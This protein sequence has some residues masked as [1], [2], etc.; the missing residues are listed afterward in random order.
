MVL[1][2]YFFILLLV[3]AFFPDFWGAYGGHIIITL[4]VLFALWLLY[5]LQVSAERRRIRA[6]IEEHAEELL[7]IVQSAFQIEDCPRCLESEIRLLSVSPNARSIRYQCINC[8]KTMHG[9]A[10]S[11]DAQKAKHEYQQLLQKAHKYHR[12]LGGSDV[13]MK[14]HFDPEGGGAQVAFN[15]LERSR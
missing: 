8:N 10:C 2:G 11:D 6:E 3:L 1:I 5:R 12:T 9:A 7:R 4:A 15:P 13:E 14:V